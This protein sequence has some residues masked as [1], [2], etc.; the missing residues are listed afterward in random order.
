MNRSL[1]HAFASVLVAS[2]ITLFASPV[3]AQLP[4]HDLLAVQIE[5]AVAEEGLVGV[6]WSLVTPEGI[7]LGAAGIRDASRG[8]RLA[9]SDRVHV[10]SV[11]KAMLATG[12][13]V[14]A[15]EGRLA[16]DARV[17]ELLP[18]VQIENPWS[19]ETP[20]LVRH[21]LDHS[22]GLDDVRFWQVFTLRGDPDAPLERGLGSQP[23]VTVRYRPGARFSYSN[24]SYLLL[25]MII[26]RVTGERYETWLDRA[27]LTPLA[28]HGS[29]F[30]FTTQ[31]G[32]AADS[33]L[34]LG[35]FAIDVTQEAYAIPVRPA[36]QFTTTAADMAVFARFLMSD[37]VVNGRPLVD[38]DLLR[39]RAVPRGTE[40]AEAGL[41][42]GYALGLLR[43]E[44]WGI[45]G[46]CHLG[47]I[48]TFRAIICVYPESQRAFFAAYNSDPEQGNFNRVDSLLASALGVPETAA[49]AVA[50]P[51]VNPE[52]WDGWYVVRP[53][54]FEQFAYLD[55]LM[56]I[57]RIAWDGA[58][59]ALRP[60]QG[61]AVQLEPL[62]AALFRAPGRRAATHVLGRSSEGAWIV[63]DG[64]RTYERVPR[65]QVVARWL[66]AGAGVVGLLYL[67]LGGGVRTVIALRRRAVRD[68]ALR[69]PAL[70]LWL[71]VLAPLLYLTQPFLAIGD[72]TVANIALAGLTGL[73]PVALVLAL[74]Q[75]M[76][77]GVASVGAV[78]D[79]VALAAALQWCVVL[80]LWGL[81]PLMLW[82]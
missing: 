55:E 16:L 29:T 78:F 18:E 23:V 44:R 59:L 48:G 58:T 62:G 80:A 10:G 9:P 66:S 72:P 39:A 30:T 3:R 17:S 76:R 71:M 38:G 69:W 67:W 45:T 12:V 20:L 46:N 70:V 32:P 52:D 77:A 54:R 15:T 33:T 1:R 24:T 26:E 8:T 42:A 28:M 35:H 21:L 65:W 63:T 47:N 73:L 50:T 5:R 11:A 57:T 40:A 34:A 79:T 7:T 13:L 2:F 25:G 60:V 49:V 14:L 56:G 27:L 22:G 36:S 64:L 53:N 74:V 51:S 6:T 43:R 81:L 4:T 41:A 37:G 19:A 75:R 82:R 31:R 68:E 61:T